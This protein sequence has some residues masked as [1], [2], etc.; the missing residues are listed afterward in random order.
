MPTL[1]EF[2]YAMER[3]G[4]YVP[5]IKQLG[6]GTVKAHGEGQPFRTTGDT[7]VVYKLDSPGFGPIA[8]RCFH[9]DRILDRTLELY[10]NLS[11]P[12]VHRRLLKPDYSPLVERIAIFPEGVVLRSA[13]LRSFTSPVVA[14]EWLQGP[15]LLRAA[16]HAC[17]GAN[18]DALH[19][20]ATGW[21]NAIEA[22]GSVQFVH[23]SLSADNAMVDL[24][25]GIV[26]VDYD[27]AWWPGLG[28]PADDDAPENYR[29]KRHADSPPERQDDFPALV[30]YV[31]LRILAASPALRQR[32]GQPA[33]VRDGGLLFTEQ[34]LYAANRSALFRELSLLEDLETR[35]LVGILREVARA[36][37]DQTPSIADAVA[38][39][40]AVRRQVDQTAVQR[41]PN[42]DAWPSNA[43]HGDERSG[44]AGKASSRTVSPEMREHLRSALYA[45]DAGAV[46]QLWPR[47]SH[48]PASS[49]LAIQANGLIQ[50]F[51]RAGL[52]E[53]VST[54]TSEE[55][56][57]AVAN[58][59]RLGVPVT[60]KGVRADRH[61]KNQLKLVERVRTAVSDDNRALL[62][63][64]G[65]IEE[66]L[67][68]GDGDD[69]LK[70]AMAM[71]LQWRMLDEAIQSD[72]D[73]RILRAVTPS[74]WSAPGYLAPDALERVQRARSRMRWK[75]E[76][77]RALRERDGPRL[78]ALIDLQPDGAAEKLTSIELKRA[79]RLIAQSRALDRLQTAMASKGDKE[80]VDAMNEVEAAGALLPPE[81]DWA[82]ISDVIDRLSLIASIRRAALNEPRD[83]LRLGRLLPAA[84]ESFGTSTPYLGSQLDIEELE[85]DVQRDTQR[86]RLLEALATGDEVAIAHAASPDP[87]GVVPSLPNE[88][89]RFVEKLLERLRKLDPLRSIEPQPR[90]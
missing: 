34:D 4:R 42:L 5:A 18:T 11:Q 20:L 61:A 14:T 54:G 56:I 16:D 68:L 86:R 31:S 19:S 67:P 66:A 10:R 30:I 13:E 74:L 7:A 32:Y 90:H 58:S 9:D 12:V 65:T 70:S 6:G 3:A 51:V 2:D 46:V 50:R 63:D 78:A 41:Q 39:A 59:R 76:M 23:G 80:L 26:L 89:R 38:A 81:L 36:P 62:A 64:F 44:H 71:A 85:R 35:A 29:H 8:L 87:Y 55:I 69:D 21:R 40:R 22:L 28:P 60:A 33:T 83:Y 47:M 72:D 48:D 73:Q 24:N 15:T 37:V 53:A 43:D 45:G 27:R 25:R 88:Q 49:H 1:A 75:E 84:R 79:G 82:G 57:D 77:R 17:R 52:D